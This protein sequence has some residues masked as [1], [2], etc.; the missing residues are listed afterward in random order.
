MIIITNI[1]SSSLKFWTDYYLGGDQEKL[2][3]LHL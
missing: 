3:S 1:I 2:H